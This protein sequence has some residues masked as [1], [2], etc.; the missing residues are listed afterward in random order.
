MTNAKSKPADTEASQSQPGKTFY[1]FA[2][3]V[4]LLLIA[5]KPYRTPANGFCLYLRRCKRACNLLFAQFLCII[6]KYIDKYYQ[7]K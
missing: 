7:T 3:C 4:L 2:T 6:F 5:D 1:Y